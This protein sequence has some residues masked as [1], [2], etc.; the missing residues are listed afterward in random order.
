M[1]SGGQRQRVA[2]GRAIVREPKIFL[3]DEPLSNLD[4]A[5]RADMRIELASLHKALG[6]TMIYVT[7]DQ[8]EAMTMADRIVVLN[9]GDHRPGRH[10]D[11]ALPR[12]GERLRRA[13]HRQPEDE[14]PARHLRRRRAG[15]GDGGAGR[16]AGADPGRAGRRHAGPGAQARDPAGACPGRRGRAHA[17]HHPHA[18]SSG[19]ASR[20]SATLRPRA[21]RTPSAWCCPARPRSAPTGR[22]RSACGRRTATSSTPRA[23]PS[24]AGSTSRPSP[25]DPSHSDD[26]TPPGPHG[27]QRK[28]AGLE[29][30]GLRQA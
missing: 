28:S 19:W 27:P 25:P 30:R 2:I 13:V 11:A 24:A 17:D 29:A 26:A 18:S 23:R 4:A 22:S 8:I 3:F 9:A 1:L 10:A 15:G 16:A 14:P 6:A 5:L 21:R 20:R 12:A 7:H